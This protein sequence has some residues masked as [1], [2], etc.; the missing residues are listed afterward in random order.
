MLE[1]VRIY[2]S[3]I[4]RYLQEPESG[5]ARNLSMSQKMS[6][7]CGCN[8]AAFKWVTKCVVSSSWPPNERRN[9]FALGW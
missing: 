9:G 1:E 3:G 4:S 2:G 8:V 5:A 6:T 7:N